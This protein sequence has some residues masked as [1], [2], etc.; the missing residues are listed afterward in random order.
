MFKDFSQKFSDTLSFSSENIFLKKNQ[1]RLS[2]K[3]FKGF[4]KRTSSL[5]KKYN[6]SEG[7]L[8]LIDIKDPFYFAAYVF[9]CFHLK[10]KPALLNSYF[11]KDQIDSVLANNTYR[12]LITDQQDLNLGL[13]KTLNI[14][15]DLMFEYEEGPFELS[16]DSEIIFF[17]SGSIQSKACVL[18]L[19]NF[20][21]NSLGSSENIPFESKDVWGLTLPLFHVGGFSLLV[22]AILA[23]AQICVL[24]NNKNYQA[25]LEEFNVSHISFVSTQFIRYLEQISGEQPLRAYPK[26]IL[27]GGSSIPLSALTKA[28]ELGAPIYKSYGMTEMASQICTTKKLTQSSKDLF[29]SGHLLNFRELKIENQKI[30]VRGPCLFKG[31]LKNNKLEISLEKEGW[32]FTKDFGVLKNTQIQILG[33]SDRI[34]QSAG[35]N[36]SPEII[37]Q[38]LL[39]IPGITKAYVCPENDPVYGLRPVAYVE[40]I[41]SLNSDTILSRLE[42]SLSGL[43]RPKTLKPWSESPKISWKQ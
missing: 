27:L 4:A 9:S 23:Q 2:F 34:F 13:E 11:K 20:F 26:Y 15:T 43:Y 7:D 25:Q 33:R 36:I 31:Y 41:D 32:F 19:R 35:E 3:K 28:L 10:L 8:V 17:T 40:K 12:L 16:L 29:T 24:D 21:Y 6:L 18:T 37:E 14:R 22:R 42:I 39:K 30:F 38:E 1:Q 5:L